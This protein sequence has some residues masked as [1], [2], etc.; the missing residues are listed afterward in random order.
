MLFDHTFWIRFHQVGETILRFLRERC[1]ECSGHC[2]SLVDLIIVKHG[3]GLMWVGCASGLTGTARRRSDQGAPILCPGS[4]ANA[5]SLAGAVPDQLAVH[6]DGRAAGGVHSSL[7]GLAS[8]AAVSGDVV[9]QTLGLGT[10]ERARG[11]DHLSGESLNGLGH[12]S[13]GG[14]HVGFVW[15]GLVDLLIIGHPVAVPGA[16]VTLRNVVSPGSPDRSE[17]PWKRRSPWWSDRLHSRSCRSRRPAA[18]PS[19]GPRCRG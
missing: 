12:G 11:L 9:E 10:G 16:L 8:G 2:V 1:N 19:H 17:C 3:G 5:A 15:F 18:H 14:G 6:G 13:G 7:Q 4:Q